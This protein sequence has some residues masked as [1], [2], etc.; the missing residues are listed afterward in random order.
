M[1]QYY[2]STPSEA[3]SQPKP[4][5]PP[6]MPKTPQQQKRLTKRSQKPKKKEQPEILESK[7]SKLRDKVKKQGLKKF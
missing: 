1:L 5:P 2:D 7:G 4:Q 6:P 3:F